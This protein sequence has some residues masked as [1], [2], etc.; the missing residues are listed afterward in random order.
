MTTV[1][2]EGLRKRFAVTVRP[3]VADTIDEIRG[4]IPRSRIVELALTQYIE[5]E[6]ENENR[7]TKARRAW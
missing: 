7:L 3:Q 1:N 6:R 4:M 5:R 2:S